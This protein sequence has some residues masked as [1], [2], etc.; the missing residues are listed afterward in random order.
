MGDGSINKIQEEDSDSFKKESN[1]RRTIVTSPILYSSDESDVRHGTYSPF[2]SEYTEFNENVGKQHECVRARGDSKNNSARSTSSEG[3]DPL[4]YK[5]NVKQATFVETKTSAKRRPF[6]HSITS[7]SNYSNTARLPISKESSFELNNQTSLVTPRVN[8]A[9]Q[10]SPAIYARIAQYYA[11]MESQSQLTSR[12]NSKDDGL[13]TDRRV[14]TLIQT[15]DK[16]RGDILSQPDSVESPRTRRRSHY[17]GDLTARR[18]V[19]LAS[20]LCSTPLS[21]PNGTSV[22]SSNETKERSAN[23]I[24]VPKLRSNKS[25]R[26]VSQ[27][28]RYSNPEVLCPSESACKPPILNKVEEPPPQNIVIDKSAHIISENKAIVVARRSIE[29]IVDIKPPQE[30]NKTQTQESFKI[31]ESINRRDRSITSSQFR[32]QSLRNMYFSQQNIICSDSYSEVI[33]FQSFASL[34]YVPTSSI[35]LETLESLRTKIGEGGKKQLHHIRKITKEAEA[36]LRQHPRYRDDP[37]I[38]LI[39]PFQTMLDDLINEIDN[40]KRKKT[41]D[42]RDELRYENQINDLI[43]TFDIIAK[44]LPVVINFYEITTLMK[45]R[46]KKESTLRRIKTAIKW[47][48]ERGKEGIQQRRRGSSNHEGSPTK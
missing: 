9:R 22:S 8:T 30:F 34:T 28:G 13:L 41:L 23:Q 10:T 32:S 6:S 40:R 4:A 29:E 48:G 12:D 26:S 44:K 2:T 14:N 5:K 15:F 43:I 16:K 27:Y 11:N 24:E 31:T 47:G 39:A 45:E 17:S 42:E 46:K 37:A 33:G 25:Q 20:S 35:Q 19:G 21:S 7:S 3:N 18:A 1:R 38:E 36:Y